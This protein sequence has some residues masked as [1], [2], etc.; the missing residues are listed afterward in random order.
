MKDLKFSEKLNAAFFQS[1]N[2][3]TAGFAS[4]NIAE[5]NEFTK[6][7]SIVLMFIG[8]CPGSTAGGIKVTTFVVLLITVISTIRG[9]EESVILKHRFATGLVYKSLTVVS[10]AIVLIFVDAGIIAAL[11]PDVSMLDAVF[12]AVSAFGTVGLSA[13]VTPQLDW[14]SKL[15]LCFTMFV[16]RV[17]PISFGL[18]I[19]MR[20]KRGGDSILPEGRMIIG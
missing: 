2:T 1:T 5:E 15:L 11:N 6:I 4:V 7:I 19:M 18:S 12:E 10:L 8:G 3:R 14:I 9:R 17:G 13:N 20:H 16:G